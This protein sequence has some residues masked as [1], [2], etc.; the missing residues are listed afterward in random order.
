MLRISFGG[1]FVVVVVVGTTGLV[2]GMVCPTGN[3]EE[4]D[5]VLDDVGNNAEVVAT[6]TRLG[7]LYPKVGFMVVGKVGGIK[8]EDILKA[9]LVVNGE[10]EVDGTNVVVVIIFVVVLVV[11]V[12]T[13]GFVVVGTIQVEGNPDPKVQ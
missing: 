5:D 4:T 3:N 6:L 1:V 7:V 2:G 10:S 11:V 9:E 13:K 8:D 12:L